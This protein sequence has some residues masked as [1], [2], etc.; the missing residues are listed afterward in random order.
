MSSRERVDTELVQLAEETLEMARAKGA[1]EVAVGIGQSQFT[2]LKRRDGEV[3]VLR[4]SAS[5]GLSLTL[6][7]GGRYS[8]NGT[9]YLE[10]AALSR[11]VDEA[12][13][14]TRRLQPDPHRGLADP[15][16][17]GPTPGVEIDTWDPRGEALPMERRHELLGQA[18]GAAR[19]R[20]AAGP[21]ALSISAT[22]T[23]Q[24]SRSLQL[25]SNGFRG[26]HAQTGHYLGVGVT[27]R[28]EGARRP[29][30][31]DFAGRCHFEELPR[32]AEVGAEA[33]RR[34]ASQV[35]ARKLDSG[36]MTLIVESRAAGR[37]VGALLG[38]AT[39]HALDQRRS[40]LEGREGAAVGSPL[41]DLRDEPLLSRGL[42]SR[43]FDGDGLAA[44][45]LPLFS[46]GVFENPL[47]GVYYGRKLGRAPTTGS[48]SN[49]L[50]TPGTSSL[51]E[52][53]E[54]VE[55]GVLVTSFIG[56]NSSSATGDFSFGIVGEAIEGGARVHPISEMNVSGNH[57]DFWKHLSA[58]GNDPYRYSSRRLPSLRFD[59][60]VLSGA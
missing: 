3:E 23:S 51:D 19:E 47:V 59:Q 56:G 17:Y 53:I 24:A 16:L 34:A 39:G 35:G 38:A 57:L 33:A 7:L 25:H 29:Q 20:I 11:F 60:V 43:T 49:L 22:Q 58:V 28:D 13:A 44:R 55:R 8:A 27:V 37:L 6:Y 2:E 4:A 12:L 30:D 45:P 5:R 26:E 21:E 40:F 46:R 36:A 32:A 50:L 41:L 52:L 31:H 54:G 48:T 1:D 18:E 14:M 42:G 9:S 10:R 15:A